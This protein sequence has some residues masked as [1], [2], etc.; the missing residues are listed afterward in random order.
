MI[1]LKFLSS[2]SLPFLIVI[3]LLSSV[4]PGVSTPIHLSLSYGTA[5]NQPLQVWFDSPQLLTYNPCAYLLIVNAKTST[6]LSITTLHW[7]FGDGSTLDVPYSTQS[8]VTDTRTHIYQS[9]GT[10][11][12][13]VTA[14]DNTGNS[15]TSS[16]TLANVTPGSCTHD[17]GITNAPTGSNAVIQNHQTSLPSGPRYAH[18]TTT[19]PRW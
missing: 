15:G 2:L 13:T 19:K 11:S 16:V 3:F 18:P 4:I 17:P 14:Y 10:Y 12:V 7:D 9:T 6:D 1:S 5:A 8:Y